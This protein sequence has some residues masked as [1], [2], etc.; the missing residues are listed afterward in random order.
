V[1]RLLK[2]GIW[3]DLCGVPTAVQTTLD[4]AEDFDEVA[5]ILRRRDVRRI[6]A[7]GNGAAYYVAHALW[8]NSLASD[9]EAPPVVAVPSGFVARGHFGWRKGDLLVAVSSSGEFRDVVEAVELGA[10]RPFIAITA[11]PESTI[12]AAADA[13]AVIAAPSQRAV[14]H[15]QVYCSGVI[16]ALAVWARAFRDRRLGD[17]VAAA[18]EVCARS[19]TAAT[20]WAESDA[21]DSIPH[22]TAAVALG[23]GRAW[24]AALETALLLRE[25]AGVPSEG[26]ETREGATS[27]LFGLSSGHLVVSVGPHR[28]PLVVEAEQRGR[29]TGA[30][31]VSVPGDEA[32]PLLGAVTSF[33]GSVALTASIGLRAGLDVDQPNW[34]NAYFATARAAN[35]DRM[36]T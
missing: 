31:V 4:K 24:T 12:G 21:F 35:S 1:N 5:A 25:V 22:P 30:I 8:L 23:S 33:P 6:V 36:P 26:A 11:R 28:D 20:D 9:N 2:T 34:V 17:A 15:T 7:T 14:T 27:S 29:E 3:Q 13:R 18:A 19:L 10:P 16:A 32:S